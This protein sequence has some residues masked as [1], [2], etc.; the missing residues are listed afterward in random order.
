LVD[1][2]ALEGLEVERGLV[3]EEIL[4]TVTVTNGLDGEYAFGGGELEAK[5]EGTMVKRG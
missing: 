5:I 4:R 2:R 1:L 3:E